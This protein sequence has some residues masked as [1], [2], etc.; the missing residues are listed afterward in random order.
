MSAGRGEWISE[1]DGLKGKRASGLI[2]KSFE[3]WLLPGYSRPFLTK[4]L[5]FSASGLGRHTNLLSTADPAIISTSLNDIFV[6]LC[7]RHC[8]LLPPAGLRDVYHFH[9]IEL[10]SR[11]KKRNMGAFPS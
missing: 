1:K 9:A 4:H 3:S 6:I 5:S 7:V 8:W 10:S 11:L 2:R